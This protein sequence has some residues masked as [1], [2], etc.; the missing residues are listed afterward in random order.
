MNTCITGYLS[1][2]KTPRIDRKKRYSQ[3][4]ILTLSIY[5]MLS[6]ADSFN[7]IVEFGHN[8]VIKRLGLSPF[9][10]TSVP[11]GSFYLG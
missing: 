5:T 10:A 1:D 2:I 11:I 7:S 6:G 9:E 8:V 3:T 4:D